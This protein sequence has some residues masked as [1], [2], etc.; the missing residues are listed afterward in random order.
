VAFPQDYLHPNEEL[1]LDLKP[2]WFQL[3]PSGASL[4]ASLLVGIIVLVRYDSD[5]L[6]IA[7]GVVILGTLI[8]FGISYARWTSTHFV[9]SS[10]RLIHRVGLVSRSGVEIPL[11]RINTVFTSQSLFERIIGAGDLTIESAGAEG[12]QEFHDIR[13]PTKV[14]NEIYVAK[15]NLEN[16]RYD[17]IAQ[18]AAGQQAAAPNPEVSIPDQIDQ[19]D[20]LRKRGVIS[21]EEFERKKAELLGRM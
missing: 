3:I 7:L 2:H 4:A 8:W 1:I 5:V 16:R 9:V 14:Q 12:R 19:L 10:D 21:D 6:S 18:S 11:D 20:A 15:E 17:R 13:K